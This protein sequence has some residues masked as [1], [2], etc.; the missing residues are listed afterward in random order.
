MRILLVERCRIVV[1]VQLQ[2]HIILL[3][4]WRLKLLF[5]LLFVHWDRL[6]G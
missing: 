4:N 2:I 3:E 5:V 6:N 1:V